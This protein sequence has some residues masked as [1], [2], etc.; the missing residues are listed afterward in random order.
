M[1]ETWN[2]QLPANVIYNAL[3]NAY[4]LITT[5]ADQTKGLKNS[6]AEPLSVNFPAS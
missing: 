3:F 2:G 6:V 1:A 5:I 4:E